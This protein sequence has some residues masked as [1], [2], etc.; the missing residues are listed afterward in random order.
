MHSEIVYLMYRLPSEYIIAGLI[1]SIF[2]V[3][4]V[5]SQTGLECSCVFLKSKLLPEY[6]SSSMHCEI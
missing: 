5:F 4:L 6:V 1:F 2:E 3:V